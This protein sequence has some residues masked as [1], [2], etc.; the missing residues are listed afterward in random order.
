[1]T[2]S[3]GFTPD[4]FIACEW[5]YDVL[6]EH[7]YGYS[8]V[9]RSLQECAKEKMVTGQETQ[10]HILE[11]LGR[12]SSMML[13]PNSLNEPF[14]PIFQDFQAGKRS[15]LPEDFTSAE[16]DF[17]EKILND[18][19]EPWLK[20]RL[21]DLLWLIRKSKNPDHARIAIE[22]YISHPIDP[23]TWHRDVDDCWERAARLS[24]QIR[25]FDKLNE[26]KSQL[27]SAFGIEYPS[28]KFMTLW[29][30]DLMDRVSI[31]HDF[32]EDI[33]PRLF[34]IGEDQKNT[35]DFNAARSYFELAAKKYQQCGDEKDWLDSLISIANCFEQEADLRSDGSNMVANSFYENA[36]QAYRSIPI[37]HRSTYGV[38]NKIQ[39]VRKKIAETG[40]ASLGEMGLIKT[41]GIDISDMAQSSIAHVTGKQN[42]EEA[43]MY[44]TG[45]YNGPEIS[46]LK[47]SAK[48]M[49]QQS[50]LSSL[51][52]SSHMSSDGRVV[53]KT[54]AANLGAG[55]DD[56]S[57]QAVL[58]RQIQQQLAIE[59][60]LVVKG[61]ILP[62][63]RQLLME[64][65][66][67]REF[68]EAACHFSPIVPQDREKLLGY[69]LWKGFEYDFG[70]AIHLLCPQVEHIVRTQ[71]KNAGAHT[72]NID[73]DGI[74]NENGLS[75]LMV[76]PEANQVF[77]DDL[78]FEIRSVFTDAIGFNLRNEVAHGLL[79]DK[80][81]SSIFTIYA[82]WMILRLVIRSITSGGDRKEE[83][84]KEENIVE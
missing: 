5:K 2:I 36:I 80:S 83:P 40:E 49:M 31:D 46:K 74:E 14:K 21:A 68:I 15:A 59:T 3:S 63:L 78:A 25:D 32:R 9:M 38:D 58:N 13:T 20:A 47:S 18:I 26:I 12:A 43:L 29:L 28:S 16:L 22:S 75:T 62:A 35:G 8:S 42:L 7:H 24:M 60:Q 82:W 71:L 4:Q 19:D 23:E 33:A 44:Y 6:P 67:T 50:P 56:P 57:N 45:L 10:A 53:A 52:G 77:G 66:V 69:A 1:M 34:Q 70:I 84:V 79:D 48:D 30:A 72:S 11:L 51:F 37:K 39:S 54:P 55:D 76:L 41:P 81:S 73:Q 64:H 17:F 61:Q 27:F 65:R